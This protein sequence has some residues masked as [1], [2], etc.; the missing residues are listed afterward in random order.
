[1]ARVM[2]GS[3]GG[4]GRSLRPQGSGSGGGSGG[5][6]GCGG[7]ERGGGIILLWG[8][9]LPAAPRGE[10]HLRGVSE[11][12]SGCSAFPDISD[13]STGLSGSRLQHG[14]GAE[15]TVARGPGCKGG[16][17]SPAGPSPAG[18][19]PAVPPEQMAGLWEEGF[20]RDTSALS[21]NLPPGFPRRR[22]G[23]SGLHW[24]SGRSPP[25]SWGL[26][27]IVTAPLQ[28]GLIFPLCDLPPLSC[29]LCTLPGPALLS[30]EQG[31]GR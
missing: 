26:G 23:G 20:V 27:V 17:P 21:L 7:R 8:R 30:F 12:G 31:S 3:F 25:V 28:S 14:L 11:G 1:M 22:F 5:S 10:E 15:S 9:P 6:S 2:P 16:R 4:G 13:S 29:L 24:R 18:P 19:S